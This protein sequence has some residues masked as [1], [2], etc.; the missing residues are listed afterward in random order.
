MNSVEGIRNALDS[1]V[2]SLEFDIRRTADGVLVL[3]HDRRVDCRHIGGNVQRPEIQEH[4]YDDLEDAT[5]THIPRLEEALELLSGEDVEARIELKQRGIEEAVESM[6]KDYE[7]KNPVIHVC[8]GREEIS[9]WFNQRGYRTGLAITEPDK[10]LEK[11]SIDGLE[12]YLSNYDVVGV[13]WDAEREMREELMEYAAACAGSVELWNVESEDLDRAVRYV[14][15]LRE[16]HV[17]LK[18]IA[19]K[20]HEKAQQVLEQHEL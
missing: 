8:Q 19:T 16:N 9:E 11:S 5:G 15:N 12:G 7:M 2:S 14:K 6:L 17:E 20:S 4:S 13:P 18:Y 10:I 3:N 1:G